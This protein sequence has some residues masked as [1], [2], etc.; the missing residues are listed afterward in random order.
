MAGW[1]FIIAAD[2]AD[3]HDAL[4]AEHGVAWRAL[5]PCAGRAMLARVAQLATQLP[6]VER[7]VVLA[8]DP[9]ALVAHGDTV[10]LADHRRVRLHSA[11]PALSESIAAIAGTAVAPWPLLITRA[12]HP[13]L[14]RVIIETFM[15]RALDTDVAVGVVEHDTLLAAY[16]AARHGWV[17]FAKGAY[18]SA[19]LFALNAPPARSA[20]DI[21]Q[22]LERH[23]TQRWR[24]VMRYGFVLAARAYTR[25]MTL[26]DAIDHAAQRGRFRARAVSIP[27]A[28]AALAVDSAADLALA[29]A[30]LKARESMVAA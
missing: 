3:K 2:Q 15:R 4:A 22:A 27:V 16:P 8:Q 19:N 13:L 30:I 7:I 28:E 17:T 23:R 21:W 5:V 10:W 12:E 29:E 20:L 1:T 11:G 24:L 18:S 25:T 14:S 9:L 6:Q 26:S